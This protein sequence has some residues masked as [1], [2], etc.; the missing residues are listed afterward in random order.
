MLMTLELGQGPYKEILAASGD[1]GFSD[2][3]T[4]VRI[5]K[6]DLQP[7]LERRGG[8]WL[9]VERIGGPSAQVEDVIIV[10]IF[11]EERVSVGPGGTGDG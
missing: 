9:V 2:A 11:A 10:D 1:G 6:V 8:V 4:G 3:V 7:D 5:E